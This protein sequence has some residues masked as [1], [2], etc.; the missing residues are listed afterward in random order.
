VIGKGRGEG[1]RREDEEDMA[2]GDRAKE[3]V[4]TVKETE[5]RAKFLLGKSTE[6]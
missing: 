6:I 5:E 2:E 3:K 4:E 1:G